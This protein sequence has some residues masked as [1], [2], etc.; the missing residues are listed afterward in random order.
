MTKKIFISLLIP[1]YNEEHFIISCLDSLLKQ[2]MA[3]SK[4][5]ILVIDGGSTDK[6]RE[7]VS[8]WKT[9]H[10][11]VNL[12]IVDNPKRITPCAFNAG[13]KSASGEY[14]TLFGAHSIVG[15]DFLGK[16][17]ETFESHPEVDACGGVVHTTYYDMNK[18]SKAIAY[19][20]QH[21]FGVG[22]GMRTPSNV[23]EGYAT[24]VAKITYKKKIFNEI[25]LFDPQ[26]IRNQDNDMNFRLTDYGGKIW[27]N[28]AIETT[29]F[30]RSSVSKMLKTAFYNSYFHS[31]FLKKH[32]VIPSLKHMVPAIFV[33][34]LICFITL[35]L[36]K[37][38][39]L[40][41]FIFILLLHQAVALYSSV[42]FR[43][44]NNTGLFLLPP[45]FLGLHFSYGIGFFAG[46]LNFFI[47][48]RKP[49]FLDTR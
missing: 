40:G 36:I 28:P 35:G 29:Y 30:S 33:L 21:P 10:P 8:S 25:G 47:L 44:K 39:W 37:K 46:I 34:S 48:N 26:F 22:R 17:V 6:T 16:V 32:H 43:R 12:E 42:P 4:Y 49:Q 31:L 15:P 23:K 14:V 45:L 5:E 24:A 41:A 1:T 19:I 7:L 3:S 2:T 11:E 9:S 38:L 27:L 13:I 18:I 20:W